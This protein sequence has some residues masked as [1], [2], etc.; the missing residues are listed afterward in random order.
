VGQRQ[1]Q[2]RAAPTHPGARPRRRPA[3]HLPH[4]S[5]LRPLRRHRPPPISIPSI[6]PALLAMQRT[7]AAWGLVI[8]L[9]AQTDASV[10]LFGAH[11]ACA[12]IARG[13]WADCLSSDESGSLPSFILRILTFVAVELASINPS[14]TYRPGLPGSIISMALDS[15]DVVRLLCDTDP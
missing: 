3:R 11:T 8:P 2:W 4:P 9:L 12:K 13:V 15:L 10:Q 5:R 6:G 1:R 14:A 7:P